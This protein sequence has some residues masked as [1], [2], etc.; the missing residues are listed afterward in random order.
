MVMYFD[1]ND[2]VSFG[3]YMISNVRR[4]NIEAMSQEASSEELQERLAYV[5]NADL[6]DWMRLMRQ[7]RSEENQSN[8]EMN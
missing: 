2:L 6:A 1:E 3:S 4:K 7:E 5:N 8:N